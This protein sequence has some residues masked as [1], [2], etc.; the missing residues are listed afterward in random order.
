MLRCCC[1]RCVCAVVQTYWDAR[2][3][4]ED[5]YD[6]YLHYS[7]FKDQLLPHLHVQPHT[8]T[9]TQRRD[10]T[11]SSDHTQSSATPPPIS[12]PPPPSTPAPSSLSGVASSSAVDVSAAGVSPASPARPRASLS[13]LIVGCGNSELSWS[14][15]EDG[16]RQVRSIDYS[17][18]VI[19]K[20]QLTYKDTPQ[21]ACH[22]SQTHYHTNAPPHRSGRLSP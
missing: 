14:M 9:H 20:M 13:V 19:D 12:L 4:V 18:V 17:Q 1:V 7:Q 11:D 3:A 16:F 21:L 8:D 2:Y 6:W 22:T 15:Y 5:K 10:S